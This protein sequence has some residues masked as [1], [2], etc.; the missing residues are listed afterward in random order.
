MRAGEIGGEQRV[1][2]PLLVIH[3]AAR[4]IALQESGGAA[5]PVG[6]GKIRIE[7]DR[8]IACRDGPFGIAARRQD[9]AQARMCLGQC[10][11]GGDR[12]ADF[13]LGPCQIV[14]IGQGIAQCQPCMGMRRREGERPRQ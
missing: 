5:V 10:R 4:E 6:P 12:G 11:I 1:P 8:V 9:E 3:E 2:P 14:K 7:R 13:A